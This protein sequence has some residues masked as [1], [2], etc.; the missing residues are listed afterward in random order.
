MSSRSS[1]VEST[2]LDGNAAAGLL[3]EIFA[4][5]PT[6]GVST[7]AGCGAT[8]LM[9]ALLVYATGM[10]MVMRCPGCDAVVLRVART[11][12]QLWLDASGARCIA[13]TIPES[14]A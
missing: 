11:G 10:G 4:T 13:F 12:S 8:G 3:S 9:G 2:R 6:V 5:E 7:C 14:V 1:S